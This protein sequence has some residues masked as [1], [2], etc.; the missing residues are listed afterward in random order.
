ML[1]RESSEVW[2]VDGVVGLVG[3]LACKVAVRNV[4]GK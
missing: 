1:L 2:D 3:L 4:Q